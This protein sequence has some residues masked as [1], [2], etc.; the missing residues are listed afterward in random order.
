[1]TATDQRHRGIVSK[2]FSVAIPFVI[3]LLT[4]LDRPT[5]TLASAFI[6]QLRAE[7]DL[8]GTAWR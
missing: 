1:M 7:C 2:P 4:P 6:A 3:Q 8:A 5:S